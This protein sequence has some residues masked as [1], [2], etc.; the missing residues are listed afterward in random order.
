MSGN[1]RPLHFSGMFSWTLCNTEFLETKSSFPKMPYYY[2]TMQSSILQQRM[3][4]HRWTWKDQYPLLQVKQ[5]HEWHFM[6]EYR[7]IYDTYTYILIRI[8]NY[9]YYIPVFYTQNGIFRSTIVRVGSYSIVQSGVSGWWWLTIFQ[10]T[11]S[12]R[13]PF[14]GEVFEWF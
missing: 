1:R 6:L 8:L 2:I 4:Y 14:T 5:E 3:C 12:K 13:F 10:L 7:I 9:I 11:C